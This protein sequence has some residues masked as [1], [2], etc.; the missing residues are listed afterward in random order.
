MIPDQGYAGERFLHFTSLHLYAHVRAREATLKSP[1]TRASL[2][3][4]CYLAHTHLGGKT[5]PRAHCGV[6]VYTGL[7]SSLQR[8]VWVIVTAV[9]QRVQSSVPSQVTK[10]VSY[11]T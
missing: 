4:L 11:Q 9:N 6:E 8:H 2:P 1:R 10:G 5:N 7:P 3:S